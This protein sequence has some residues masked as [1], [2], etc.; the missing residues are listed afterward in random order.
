MLIFL[1]VWQRWDD[2]LN[3]LN[4]VTGPGPGARVRFGWNFD[5]DFG[6]RIL[7][8]SWWNFDCE[9]DCDFGGRMRF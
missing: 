8:V 2:I 3:F 6:G 5:C 9:F 7:T 4:I 1:C